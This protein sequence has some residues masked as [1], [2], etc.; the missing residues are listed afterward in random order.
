MSELIRNPK[1]MEK[2]QK[3]VMEKLKEKNGIQETDIVKLNYLKSIVME[4]LRLHPP[5]RLI[6]R[7]CRKT[8]E[9]L[10]YEIEAGT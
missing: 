2:A 8:C 5:I 10:G 9:V 3:E 4:T 7:M 6:P 1:I